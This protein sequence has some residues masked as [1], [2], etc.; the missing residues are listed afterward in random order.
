MDICSPPPAH[1]LDE[2]QGPS[3]V[4]R[5]RRHSPPAGNAPLLA[6]LLL[7]CGGCHECCGGGSL[8]GV[9]AQ[10]LH[11][12]VRAEPARAAHDPE[13]ARADSPEVREV[14]PVDE[15]AA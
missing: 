5:G 6:P 1:L 7:L 10:Q 13:G 14:A 3:V 4:A 9:L 2:L 11:S 8:L 12:H 15:E